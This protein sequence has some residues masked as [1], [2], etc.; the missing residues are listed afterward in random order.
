[1]IALLL[2]A[3]LTIS[4]AQVDYTADLKVVRYEKAYGYVITN[5]AT[6]ATPKTPLAKP[7]AKRVLRAPVRLEGLGSVIRP[8]AAARGEIPSRSEPLVFPAID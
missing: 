7:P 8:P 4:Q 1:M 3:A 6:A 5:G 2:A